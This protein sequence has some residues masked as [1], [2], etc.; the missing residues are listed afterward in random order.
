MNSFA[1]LITHR[2]STRKYKD[3]LLFPE[4][5]ELI[6]KAALLAPSARGA[7][8]WQFVVVEDKEMLR[9]LSQCK[10]RHAA[11]VGDCA[12]AVV[13]VGD[14]TVTDAWIDDAAIAAAF[15]QLQAEDIGIGSCWC[16][17]RNR[18]TEAGTSAEQY[19]RDLLDIPQH[20][21]VASIIAFGYKNVVHEPK[22]SSGVRWEHVHIGKF[23]QPDAPLHPPME[24]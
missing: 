23:R 2:R 17:V 21:G 3:E 5:V 12:M 7:C 15:M 8:S 6:L 13:V 20:Y 10:Q 11:F 14:T 18:F 1:S 22:D 24:A 9:K 4:E 19:V 16:H